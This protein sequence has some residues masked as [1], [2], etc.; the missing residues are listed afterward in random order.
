MASRCGARNELIE[1]IGSGGFGT[2]FRAHDPILKREVAVK[3]PREGRLNRQEV[4]SLLREARAAARLKH[5]GIVQIYDAGMQEEQAYIACELV[6]GPSLRKHLAQHSV[7]VGQAAAICRRVAEALQHAHDLGVIHRDLNPSNIL[8]DAEENPY[9]TDFGLARDEAEEVHERDLCFAGTLAYMSPEQ[10]RG[11]GSPAAAASDVYSL[12]VVLF[13]MLTG[14][15]P[16]TGQAAELLRQIRE[17][18]VPPPRQL[19]PCVPRDLEAICLKCL[20]QDPAKRYASAAELA[21]DL[22]RYLSNE[23]V[24]ARPATLVG[25]GWRW[26]RRKPAL[27]SAL[28]LLAAVVVVASS[29]VSVSNW[30]AIRALQSA[31]TNLYFH[32][33]AAAYQKWLINSPAE[34]R[35]TL[36]TCPPWMRD[37]E[38]WYLHGLFRTPALRLH[39]AGNSFAFS[40]DGTRIVTAGGNQPAV[41]VWD[42]KSG[43]GLLSLRTPNADK[44]W[45]QCVDIAPDGLTLVSGSGSDGALRLWNAIDGTFLRIVGRHKRDVLQVH[46]VGDGSRILSVGR[47]ECL[48]LWE[49]AT[50]K[51]LQ[52]FRLHPRRIRAVAISPVDS[53]VVVSTV[54]GGDAQ[55]SVWDYET[56]EKIEDLPSNAA[57]ATGLAFSSDGRLLA[58]AQPRNVLQI[59]ETRP[60]QHV[61]TITGPVAAY[62]CPAFD[63]SGQRIAAEAW[64][65][66][67]C[68]WD[69]SSGQQLRV[70]RGH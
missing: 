36:R 20:A 62:P 39:G 52:T 9:I 68:V 1:Q 50:G 45:T 34:A 35:D 14:R 21:D 57:L 54:H 30:K 64:D 65:G 16:F 56:G 38:W 29:A 24:R 22:R 69:V 47:D 66:S 12:G 3:I 4:A 27:A 70:Y 7:S 46:F 63:P 48:T 18:P 53:R 13:E 6:N 23:P 51:E 43:N 44:D 59:W 26:S 55:V 8:L 67:I 32:D 11:V 10:L 28:A 17:S 33:I 2:V 41:L 31:E 49:T 5:P 60:W 37:F 61:Q 19:N 40:R 25:R 15:C 42:A 58:A